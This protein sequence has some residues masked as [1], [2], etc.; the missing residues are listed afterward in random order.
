[1]LGYVFDK[2]KRNKKKFMEEVEAQ[3][4][5]NGVALLDPEGRETMSIVSAGKYDENGLSNEQVEKLAPFLVDFFAFITGDKTRGVLGTFM[6]R[7]NSMEEVVKGSIEVVDINE[8]TASGMMDIHQFIDTLFHELGHAVEAQSKLRSFLTQLQDHEARIDNYADP[9]SL[10]PFQA[11]MDEEGLDVDAFKEAVAN[12]KSRRPHLWEQSQQVV[13]GLIND[14]GYLQPSLTK[15]RRKI[16]NGN[17]VNQYEIFQAKKETM[18][19]LEDTGAIDKIQRYEDAYDRLIYIVRYSHKPAELGADAV[20]RYMQNPKLM[21]QQYPKLA[22]LVRKGVNDSRIRKY[23]T[24]HSLAGLLG[25]A[26]MSAAIEAALSG[27]DDEERP[28]ILN[29]LQPQG[30]LQQASI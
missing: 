15:I 1:L 17:P 4:M 21:K 27:E 13:D 10:A 23:I 19:F 16:V 12:S 7:E 3:A 11:I 14:M 30:I 5:K 24:F 20:A 8:P 25:A 29:L 18:K 6:A 22:A 2:P 26:G 9:D 28:G